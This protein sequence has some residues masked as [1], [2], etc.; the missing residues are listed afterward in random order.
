PRRVRRAAPGR[1]D[2]RPGDREPVGLQP[3]PGHEVEVLLVAVVVVAGDVPGVPVPHPSRGVAVGVPDARPAP[4][5]PGG[6]LDLVGRGR[7]AEDEPLGQC[8]AHR[9]TS[10]RTVPCSAG[11][12]SPP[13]TRARKSV[14]GDA[15]TVTASPSRTTANRTSAPSSGLV[16][17]TS[18]S[19]P[20]G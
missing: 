20:P 8:A 1:L 12:G 9:A 13:A 17:R 2:A 7:R 4:V 19:S 3:E 11:T 14:V 10:R 6:A 18:P 5:L 15:V 16:T